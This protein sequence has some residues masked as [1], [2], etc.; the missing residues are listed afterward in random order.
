MQPFI[1]NVITFKGFVKFSVIVWYVLGIDI[2]S[3]IYPFK[4]LSKG[5]FI[6]NSFKNSWVALYL[7][8]VPLYDFIEN[9]FIYRNNE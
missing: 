9:K 8:T 3:L 7:V 4:K 5:I 2:G 6:F 1:G